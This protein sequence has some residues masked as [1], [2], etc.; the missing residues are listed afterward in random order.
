MSVTLQTRADGLAELIID[1]PIDME[2]AQAFRDGARS[3]AGTPGLGAVLLRAAEGRFF[4]P[5]G[6]VGWMV[7]QDDVG[8]GLRSLAGTLHDGLVALAVLDAPVVAKVQGPAAGAGL[9][10]VL[11]ADVAIAGASAVFTMAYTGVGLSPDGGASWLLPRLVGR[12]AAMDIML[13]NR[14]VS[15]EEAA[16]LGIVTRAVPDAELD[17]AVEEYLAMLLSGPTA[18]YG[19]IK[20]LLALS[21]QQDFEQQL[22]DEVDAISALGGSPTGAEGISAFVE[23]RRPVFPAA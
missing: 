11:G 12:R 21:S 18:S 1:G 10:L 19:A 14:R 20:R 16:A 2:W 7:G 9:S 6:D 3:L 8:A 5:G 13:S 15:A 22:A 4:C 23:K 17:A